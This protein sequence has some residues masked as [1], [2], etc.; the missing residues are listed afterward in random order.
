[1]AS[2]KVDRKNKSK[3]SS[4]ICSSILVVH[5]SI[6]HR[7]NQA[8]TSPSEIFYFY[9]YDLNSKDKFLR[10]SFPPQ[11]RGKISVKVP[12]Y[13]EHCHSISVLARSGET[14]LIMTMT[15]LYKEA[16]RRLATQGAD[17]LLSQL[18]RFLFGAPPIELYA[19]GSIPSE[20]DSQRLFTMIERLNRGYPLQ[21]LLGEW[22]FYGISL[23]VGEGVL[24][25]RADTE[26]LVDTRCPDF[27]GSLITQGR[28]S[29]QWKRGNRHCNSERDLR[30]PFLGSRAFF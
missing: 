5:F 25:P 7:E 1:M 28:R 8:R 16:K 27:K 14:E 12:F 11:R 20:A 6:C 9:L 18:F 3:K 26:I 19:K 22:E 2:P 23:K 21:Y 15:D 4:S 24:I 10:H 17:F 13:R 30:C 29:L